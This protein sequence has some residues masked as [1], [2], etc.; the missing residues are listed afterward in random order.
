MAVR[1]LFLCVAFAALPLSPARAVTVAG[2]DFSQYFGDGLLSTDGVTGADTLSSNYSAF[3]PTFGAG[4]E[5]SAYGTMYVNGQFGSTD[6]D[7]FAPTPNV[8][9]TMGSL[10]A[11]LTAPLVGRPI[12]SA[13]PFDT[14]SVLLTE[15][16]IFALPLS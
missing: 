3:D 14:F 13:V 5:S 1:T 4:V 15:G 10:T 8:V 7:P 11:N 6:V 16:Q 9:P 12:G 2:W